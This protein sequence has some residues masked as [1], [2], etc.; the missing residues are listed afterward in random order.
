MRA[1][2]AS[3]S[4]SVEQRRAELTGLLAAGILRMRK[5]RWLAGEPERMPYETAPESSAQGLEDSDQT[6]LSVHAG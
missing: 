6:V 2:D 3:L 4:L 1:A 5:R